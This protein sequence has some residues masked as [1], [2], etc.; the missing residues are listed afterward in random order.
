M[1]LSSRY[2]ISSRTNGLHGVPPSRITSPYRWNVSN[3]CRPPTTDNLYL[4]LGLRWHHLSCPRTW[5]VFLGHSIPIHK[6]NQ[7]LVWTRTFQRVNCPSKHPI[8]RWSNI[9][10]HIDL[11]GFVWLVHREPTTP[12]AGYLWLRWPEPYDRLQEIP[13]QFR[14]EGVNLD[15]TC[16]GISTRSWQGRFRLLHTSLQ[17]QWRQHRLPLGR[18]NPHL[19]PHRFITAFGGTH[20]QWHLVFNSWI[21]RV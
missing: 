8:S 4:D 15:Q 10:E 16:H 1:A 18:S 17:S 2:G 13:G 19:F 3:S 14:R 7:T 9:A 12:L 21:Q 11:D 5:S 6:R 20:V